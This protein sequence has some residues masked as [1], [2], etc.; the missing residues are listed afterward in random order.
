MP[1]GAGGHIADALAR[2]KANMALLKKKRYFHKETAKYQ[3][4]DKNWHLQDG[5]A[6]PARLK[7][8]RKQLVFE[9]RIDLLKKLLILACSIALVSWFI[10]WFFFQA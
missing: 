9:K 8:L 10:Y 7:A 3:N 1:G 2:Y 4:R 6:D 5:L